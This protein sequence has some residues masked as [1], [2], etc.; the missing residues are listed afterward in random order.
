MLALDG[1]VRAFVGLPD[2]S[3]FIVE[4]AATGTEV[5]ARLL[6]AGAAELL[7]ALTP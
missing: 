7:K 4:E 3:E 1:S 6:A 5:A 2:G